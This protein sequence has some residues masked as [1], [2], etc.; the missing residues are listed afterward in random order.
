M[1]A[2]T[3]F[4]GGTA[5]AL[6]LACAVQFPEQAAAGPILGLA[7]PY[8][9]LGATGVSTSGDGAT[10]NGS[11]G[12]P[13]AVTGPMTITGGTLNNAGAAAALG[14]AN[15]ASTFLGGFG[16]PLDKSGIDLGGLTLDAGVYKF[17]SSAALDG[18]LTLDAQGNNNAVFIFDIGTALVTGSNAKVSVIN[19]GSGDGLFWLVGSQAT[20]GDSTILEGN[21]IAGTAIILDPSAQIQCGRAIANTAVTMAGKTATNP[22]NLVAINGV[23]TGCAGGLEGGFDLSGGIFSRVDSGG[24]I[25]VP[26]GGG[27]GTPPG[28]VAS[29]PEPSTLALFGG[30]FVGLLGLAIRR[31]RVALA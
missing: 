25:A 12:S 27:L 31:R 28:P 16:S 30:G 6:A 11:V 1:K 9:V 29:V 5:I 15:A 22:T 3:F 4:V 20:L 8:A 23:P 26:E 14:A 2:R 13:T 19:G 24:F 10:I 21:I 17:S 7:D 18:T